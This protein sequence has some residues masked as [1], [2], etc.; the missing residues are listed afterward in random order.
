MALPVSGGGGVVTLIPTLPRRLVPTTP[1]LTASA[2]VALFVPGSDELHLTLAFLGEL[3]TRDYGT[4]IEEVVRAFAVVTP[5]ITGRMNGIGHFEE[6]EDGVP[7]FAH[8]DSPDLAM[9]RT[10]LVEM[11]DRAGVEFSKEHGFTPHITLEYVE[12]EE[13][14]REIEAPPAVDITFDEVTL[15][16]G[17]Q[18]LS[19]ALTGVIGKGGPGSGFH[20][21][22]GRPGRRGGSSASFA[23]GRII[24]LNGAKYEAWSIKRGS[25][26]KLNWA[27]LSSEGV[28][29]LV[30]REGDFHAAIG[31]N[32]AGRHNLYHATLAHE[33]G[34]SPDEFDNSVVSYT[35]T[36]DYLKTTTIAAGVGE[37][38]TRSKEQ[39][40]R[41]ALANIK[42][43]IP[44]LKDVGVPTDAT[45]R[46]FPAER[47]PSVSL[48]LEEWK[49]FLVKGGPGSGHH[50]HRGRPGQRGGSGAGRPAPVIDDKEFNFRAW[51]VGAGGKFHFT[52]GVEG[53][54]LVR[55]DA[56]RL[57]YAEGDVEGLT[58]AE[59]WSAVTGGNRGFDDTVRF[60]W[61][62]RQLAVDSAVSFDDV[63]T[64]AQ[65]LL[66][67]G[68]DED[69]VLT[70]K[71]A[72]TSGG[73]T[74]ALSEWKA[75]LEKGGP[76]SG[77]FGHG[78]RPGKR[79][80][81]APS[82][83]GGG[84][85]TGL[86]DEKRSVPARMAGVRQ[87]DEMLPAHLKANVHSISFVTY[88]ELMSKDYGA[89][90]KTIGLHHAREDG[91]GEIYLKVPPDDGPNPDAFCGYMSHRHQRAV[92][93]HE[94]GHSVH[95]MF[96]P[97]AFE[98]VPGTFDTKAIAARRGDFNAGGNFTANLNYHYA[99]S[100]ANNPTAERHKRGRKEFFATTF[101]EYMYYPGRLASEAPELYNWYKDDF[102]DG[103]EF[104]N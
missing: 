42:R 77:H 73:E 14:A 13:E 26:E 78:G 1:P 22:R 21:H 88:D 75:L 61:T 95:V 46:W 66:H 104:S 58:H 62:G 31:T 83:G 90:P 36:G 32:K 71:R 15:A 35:W 5:P 52:D 12:S 19:F 24:T 70:H 72:Y 51:D 64:M 76:G 91:S 17:D 60:G 99:D 2:V 50:G 56:K 84:A 53:M 30:T 74:F 67:F 4:V 79:G 94:V 7:V 96:E 39:F 10:R 44:V 45:L 98:D 33:V 40:D 103:R 85:L 55:R 89:G 18:R 81:S 11:L 69:V 27:R 47:G 20:G 92:L 3:P 8:F 102:F 57:V 6:V 65:A 28:I 49:S 86:V 25:G 38:G 43:T 80:G 101:A 63:K 54:G 82:G 93:A 59:I 100:M 97:H 23:L 48:P 16:I 9:Y 37:K 68:V 87:V 34:I 41:A 29:M